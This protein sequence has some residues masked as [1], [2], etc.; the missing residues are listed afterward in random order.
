[1]G[2]ASCVWSRFRDSM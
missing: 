2:C 1:M